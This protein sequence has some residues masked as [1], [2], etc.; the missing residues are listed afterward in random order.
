M[1]TFTITSTLV[2][3]A[4]LA[5]AAPARVAA[6]QGPEQGFMAQITFEGATPDAFFTQ[7][8]RTDNIPFYITNPLSISHIMS[9]GGASCTFFGI[10][11]SVTSVYGAQT[12]DVGPP[13]TQL[14]GTCW[15]L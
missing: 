15:A 2:L 3:L 8:V 14:S 5:Q 4:A 12:V 6:R 11:D 10:N 9:Q 1:Q 13:Q 7:S